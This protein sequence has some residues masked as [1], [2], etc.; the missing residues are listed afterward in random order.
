MLGDINDFIGRLRAVLPPRWFSDDSPNLNA[1]LGCLATPWSWIFGLIQGVTAQARIATASGNWLDVVALDFFGPMLRRSIG[2]PDSA[3]RARIQWALARSAGTRSSLYV[4]ISHLTGFPPLIFEPAN[5]RDTG[6]YGSGASRMPLTTTG[7]AYGV[8]GGWG[9]L[10]LPFQFFIT[11]RRPAIEGVS[12]TAGYD[13][14][15]GGYGT[16][17]IGYVDLALVPGAVTDDDI[18]SAICSVLPIS[19]T[20]WLR[21]I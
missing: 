15:T 9:N 18:Q 1:I 20:A 3:Y 10:D 13:T 7:F 21:I 8:T 4:T 11:V 16:G 19:T 2:E 5:C 6:S 12:F 17:S 14:G